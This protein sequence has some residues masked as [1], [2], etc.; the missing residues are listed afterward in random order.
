MKVANI[1]YNYVHER[2]KL[3]EENYAKTPKDCDDKTFA[4]YV[5]K[6]VPKEGENQE[7]KKE[8]IEN[9]EKFNAEIAKDFKERDIQCR[10]I[11]KT[12]KRECKPFTKQ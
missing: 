9:M 8:D 6:N 2:T 5:N 4:I 11:E 12:Q 3:V 10:K 1:I 7:V